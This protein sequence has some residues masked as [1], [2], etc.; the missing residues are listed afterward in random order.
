M[1]T[2]D[3][4]AVTDREYRQLVEFLYHEA[5]LLDHRNLSA[6]LEL[7]TDDIQYRVAAP[8]VHTLEEADTEPEA[9]FMDEDKSS[10][11]T[12]VLQ[13]TTPEYTVAEN[14]PSL[15]RR[16]V[17]NILALRE[18]TPH[19]FAVRSHL[20]LYRSRGGHEPPYFF[21]AER[22]DV[23]RRVDDHIR[24]AQRHVRLDEVVFGTR[25]MSVFF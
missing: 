1:P 6:W 22:R 17:T 13:L 2:L 18:D 25:N 7:L 8:T 16:F 9:V 15:T 14:P 24:L 20:L 11:R 21:S 23:M 5:Q 19:H 12:R 3:A 10:L 4:Q